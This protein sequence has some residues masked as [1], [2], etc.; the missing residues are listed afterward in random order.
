M[1]PLGI[2]WSVVATAFLGMSY[3]LVL[4]YCIQVRVLAVR[5]LASMAA[6]PC[7][8][9]TE[10]RAVT[11]AN[12]NSAKACVACA[13]AVQDAVCQAMHASADALKHAQGCIDQ[14]ISSPYGDVSWCGVMWLRMRRTLIHC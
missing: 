13:C 7:M 11:L 2:V 5:V 14:D 10:R 12:T 1:A 4:L 9:K 3:I 8:A 6:C